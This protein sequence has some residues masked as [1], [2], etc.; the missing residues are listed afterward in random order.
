MRS[1][2]LCIA[3]VLAL[4]VQTA[5]QT[6]RPADS[7]WGKTLERF[8]TALEDSDPAALLPLLADDAS[9]KAFDSKTAD[10]IRL[11]ARTR[12]ATLLMSKAYVQAPATIASDVAEQVKNSDVPDEVKRHM[13]VGDEARSRRANETA[14]HWV[15][16]ALGAKDGDPVAVILFWCDRSST[17]EPAPSPE[18]VFVLVRGQAQGAGAPRVQAIAFGNP[19]TTGN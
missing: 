5:G 8:T 15:A 10:A 13:A 9:I 1:T 16:Q 18:L 3:I 14:A 19:D 17:G 6:T 4:V 7:T 2:W 11:L 12:K